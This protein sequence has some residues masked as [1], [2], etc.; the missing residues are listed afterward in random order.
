M[1]APKTKGI[2]LLVEGSGTALP[3]NSKSEGVLYEKRELESP[4]SLRD[5]P[6]DSLVGGVELR[7]VG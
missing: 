2:G 6:F 3:V 7:Y 4:S 5:L 1:D